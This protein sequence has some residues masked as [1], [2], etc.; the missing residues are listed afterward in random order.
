M[1][2]P[3]LKSLSNSIYLVFKNFTSAPPILKS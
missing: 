1:L 2:G 3:P